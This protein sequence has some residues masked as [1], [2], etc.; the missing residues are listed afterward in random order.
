VQ[1]ALRLLGALNLEYWQ[2]LGVALRDALPLSTFQRALPDEVCAWTEEEQREWLEAALALVPRAP[3]AAVAVYREVPPAVRAVPAPFRRPIF[4]LLR[5]A[6]TGA[7]PMEVETLVPVIG[8][9][10]LD[11]PPTERAEALDIARHV[12]AACPRAAPGLVRCLARVVEE[13]PGERVR[14]W[15]EHGLTLARAN[16]DAGRAYFALA[17]RTS[18]RVLHS[19]PTAVALEEVEGVLHRYIQM[20]SGAP[21]VVRADGPFRLRPP[22]EES[23]AAGGVVLPTMIDT[24][25][26]WEDN[27]RLYRVLAAFLAAR[28]EFGTYTSTDLLTHL[29]RKERP[30]TVEECFLLTDGYRVARRLA[31]TY[32]G[33]RTDLAWAAKAL[34]ERWHDSVPS[35]AL[36]LDALLAHAIAEAGGPVPPWVAGVGAVVLPCL[37]PLAAPGATA[38]D[39]LVI[40]ELLVDLLTTFLSLPETREPPDLPASAE[41]Y[42]AAGEDGPL[43]GTDDAG[44]D[45][46][47]A[48]G[49]DATLPPELVADLQLHLGELAQDVTTAGRALTAEELARLIES[50]LAKQLA[51]GRGAAAGQAGLYVTQL[52]GKLLGEKRSGLDRGA[53]SGRRHAPQLADG[54]PVFFYDEWD[55]VIADYRPAWCCLREVELADDAGLFF[56]RTLERYAALVPEI[57]RHFQRVR[58][59]SWRTLRGLEDGEDFD[60]SA[61]IDARA[62]RR[63]RR[64][65]SS[66]LYTA[67]ARLEREVA[68]LFLLDMSASTDETATVAGARRR[69]IDIEKEALVIMAAALEEIGDAYAIY[70]FSGQGRHSVEFY[71]I[72]EFT[73]RITAGAKGRIGGIQPRCSTRMGAALRHSLRKMRDVRAPNRHLILI[74]D[75]FPQ[76]LDYGEDRRSYA[77]GISDT[78]TA[79]REIEAARI[80]PFCI[81]VDLAGHDYLREMCDPQRYMVIENVGDLPRE[82]PKIYQRLIRAA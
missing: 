9:L 34:L 16:P 28:R 56:T 4:Q 49:A 32:A 78:A 80:K 18:V 68:T 25:D 75:G 24:F 26:T 46:P 82:L 42:L 8:A 27:A 54:G 5:I 76:D 81:T 23:P 11:V 39:A 13:A 14:E 12:A 66:K 33:L 44:S 15:A 41:F 61:V 55:H 71:S 7:D 40:A 38:H 52:A 50:G 43:Y 69:I 1:R 58:P 64:S 17:S 65:P 22:L 10:V 47:R 2:R 60:L 62:E 3:R 35:A 67:R 45:A 72:K 21:A 48:P 30:A 6:A 29:R 20:L 79:L 37:A 36:L 63:A 77:Y 74:S 57:R 19:S 31:V 73:E 51:Q 70:G 59:E 53:A